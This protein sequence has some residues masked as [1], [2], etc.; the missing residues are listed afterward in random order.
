MMEVK[1]KSRKRELIKSIAIVFLVILLVLTFFS[2]T[3]MNRSLAEVAT[4]S[5]ASATINT[6]I[7]G[8][9]TV[10]ANE[11]YEVT[12]QQTREVRSICVRVGDIVSQGDLLFVLAD[13]ESAEL[14]SAQEQLE[15][16]NMQYEQRLLNLAREHANEDRAVQ[17]LREELEDAVRQ[18]DENTVTA[19]EL[20]ALEGQLASAR[21]DLAQSDRVLEQLN[22]MLSEDESY[23]QAQ[24]AVTRLT[25]EVENARSLVEEY[26]RQISELGGSGTDLNQRLKEAQDAAYAAT[27]A[28]DSA[29]TVYKSDYLKLVEE[30]TEDNASAKP[31]FSGVADYFRF[32]ITTLQETYLEAYLAKNGSSDYAG[33]Y[34]ALVEKYRDMQAKQETLEQLLAES[35]GSWYDENAQRTKLNEQLLQAKAECAAAEQKLRQA[36]DSLAAA[37]AATAS[38]RTQI[39]N[40]QTLQRQH[41]EAVDELTD[42]F[43]ALNEKKQRYDQAVEQI[44]QTERSIEDALAGKNIDEQLENLDLQSLRKQIEKA[45]ELVDKYTGESVDT[46]IR[47]NVSGRIASINVS[48]GKEASA[49]MSMATIELVDRGYMLKIPVTN[50]QSRQ[51]RVGDTADVANYYWGG[52]IEAVLETIMPDPANPGRGKLLVFRVTGEVDAGVNLTLSIGQRSSNYDTVVP[53]SAL[54]QDANGYF[55]LVITVKSSPLS[56][57]YIATRVDVQVLAEDDTNAAVSGLSAGDF[58]ITTSNKPVEPGQ[59]VRM[60]ENP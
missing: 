16:L 44:K 7:R 23:T 17:L 21:S 19:E 5:I 47:A 50:E 15:A 55:V 41:T 8:S 60:V 43:A 42:E 29:W 3:I 49:G 2:N 51:V 9:G 40:A 11:N 25:G 32:S 54:R 26:E 22:A 18:R 1:E 27:D 24:E 39:S 6:R 59:Q 30:V 58:V 48:A 38:L 10:E 53:K 46:E 45:Q 12:L 57:R 28:M 14:Q 37:Q 20:S 34:R 33:A 13:V 31:A 36:E 4:K 56:N 35:N 52:E